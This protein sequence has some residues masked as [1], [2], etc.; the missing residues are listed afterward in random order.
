[1]FYVHLV[2]PFLCDKE[3]YGFTRVLL[4]EERSNMNM[5][6]M[7]FLESSLIIKREEIRGVLSRFVSLELVRP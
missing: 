5:D 4:E 2:T 1:M 6:V 7:S 3:V